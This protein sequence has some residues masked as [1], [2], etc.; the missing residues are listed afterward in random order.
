MQTFISIVML[1]KNELYNLKESIPLILEQRTNFPYEIIV[2]DSGSSDGSVEY[3][4]EKVKIEGRLSLHEIPAKEFHHART[5]NLGIKLCRGNMVVFLG[6]D[7]IPSNRQWLHNIVL[8]VVEG[9]PVGIAASYG[10][11]IPRSDVDIGNYCRMTFN[12]SDYYQIKDKNTKLS[13]KELFFFSS[14]NC[15]I[16]LKMLPTPYFEESLP[17][18]E[19]IT[20][21]YK[22]INNNLKIAYCPE[23]AVIHSHNYNYY[24][25]FMRYF[26]NAVTYTQVG[27]WSEDDKSINND[28]K[29]FLKHSFEIIQ[30]KKVPD[31]LRFCGF[32][33]F[34]AIGLILGLNYSRIPESICKRFLSKYGTVKRG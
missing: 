16:N 22:I 1:V 2:I 18:N 7:A 13:R 31:I 15:C 20:L 29:K 9:E 14:A 3:I 32:L 27:I 5:R 17:V 4:Q 23:A 24:N 25:I 6:G 30:K 10:K 8:P 28:R 11:Q 21:S 34:A 26:D 12:Y 33:V 19:D